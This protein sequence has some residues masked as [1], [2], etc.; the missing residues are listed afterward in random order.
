MQKELLGFI[1]RLLVII[2]LAMAIHL[3]FLK[4]LNYAL[5]DNLIV[6]A[7]LVNTI[8][9]V[10]FYALLLNLPEKQ[11]GNTGFIFMGGSLLKFLLFFLLFYP[12]YKADGKMDK[13][14]FF[15]FFTPYA[16]NLFFETY[17]LIRRFNKA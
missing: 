12:D 14:E 9:A 10:V 3:G 7:Y 5:F 2:S 13:L 8:L 1:A 6:N 17:S 11:Q 16:I 15:A 4:I